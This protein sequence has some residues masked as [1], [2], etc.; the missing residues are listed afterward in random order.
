MAKLSKQQ[1]FY[2]SCSLVN[3]MNSFQFYLEACENTFNQPGH[4]KSHIHSRIIPAAQGHFGNYHAYD[5]E[6]TTMQTSGKEV[7]LFI[8]PLMSQ[9]WFFNTR[10]IIFNNKLMTYIEALSTFDEVVQEAMPRLKEWST[11]TRKSIPY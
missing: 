3:Y 7:E 9:M 2:G 4:K 1:G 8:S 11:R 6:N 10:A 5:D